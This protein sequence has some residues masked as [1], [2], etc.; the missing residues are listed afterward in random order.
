[1]GRNKQRIP[2][3]NSYQIDRYYWPKATQG[4][5][6]KADERYLRGHQEAKQSLYLC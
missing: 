2:A 1:M 3:N 6:R 5:L 4:D